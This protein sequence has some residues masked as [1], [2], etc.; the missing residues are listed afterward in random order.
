MLSWA[1]YEKCFITSGPGI[2]FHI[3]APIT[4]LQP[5]SSVLIAVL[6]VIIQIQVRNAHLVELQVLTLLKNYSRKM[7][8]WHLNPLVI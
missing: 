4:E 7:N 1:E 2:F 5:V 3:T 6:W 8:L